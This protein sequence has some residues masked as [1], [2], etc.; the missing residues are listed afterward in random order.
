MS[1]SSP[2]QDV[3]TA[4]F[5]GSRVYGT[6]ASVALLALAC[7]AA[8][9]CGDFSPIIAWVLTFGPGAVVISLASLFHDARHALTFVLA[10]T[11]IR[12]GIAGLGA[13]AVLAVWP[14]LPRNAFL[15]WLVGMYLLALAVEIYL[16][17]AKFPVR[18]GLNILLR[19]G[20]APNSSLREAGR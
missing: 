2:Q 16:T 10:S 7:P 4:R 19:S 15:F 17:L 14:S 18:D 6:V 13:L 11:A 1:S 3:L 8:A 12:L 20:E 5:Q 9:I